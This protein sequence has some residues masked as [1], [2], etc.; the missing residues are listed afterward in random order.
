MKTFFFIIGCLSLGYLHAQDIVLKGGFAFPSGSY[1][2]ANLNKSEDGF[3]TTGGF[4]AL[5]INYP[6]YKK[7]SIC[8]EGGISHQGFNTSRYTEQYQAQQPT[9]TVTI[10][11]KSQYKSAY[12]LIGA[13]YTFSKNKF[14][15]GVRVLMGMNSLST[16]EY[17]IRT[18]YTN[19]SGTA[20][21]APETDIAFAIAWGV[22]VAY[23]LPKNFFIQLSLD[24]LN[25]K[26]QFRDLY[27]SSDQQYTTQ[28]FEV[29]QLGLGIGYTL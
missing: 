11:M 16:P 26:M 24:N 22:S 7:F 6:V 12:A 13:G 20:Y 19:S 9:G 17:T 3:A 18:A 4:G 25:S 28:P 2:N 29:Y 5:A 15:F 27:I 8:A 23:Q 10:D 1:A 14:D 21:F